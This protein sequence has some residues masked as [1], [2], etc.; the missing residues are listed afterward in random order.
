MLQGGAARY[1][2]SLSDAGT[3]AAY[4]ARLGLLPTP[5]LGV[6]LGYLGTQNNIQ[7]SLDIG[8]MASTLKTNEGYADVRL[9]ILPGDLTPYVFVVSSQLPVGRKTAEGD[10]H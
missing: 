8:R 3:G 9:N 2:Q 10:T 6:E 5:M 1:N 7:E 4:G